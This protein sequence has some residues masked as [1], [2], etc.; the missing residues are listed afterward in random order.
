MKH[1]FT[2]LVTVALLAAC[3]QVAEPEWSTLLGADN[4]VLDYGG[5]VPRQKKL[6]LRESERE[7]LCQYMAELVKEGATAPVSQVPQVVLSGENYSLNFGQDVVVLKL[8]GTGGTA[9]RQYTRTR[10]AEDAALLDL[11]R[12]KTSTRTLRR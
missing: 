6:R 5:G 7:M 4:Y 12:R 8:S 11:L 9:G 1:I 3:A 10:H 2:A